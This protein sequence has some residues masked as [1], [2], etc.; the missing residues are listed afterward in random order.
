MKSKLTYTE[1]KNTAFLAEAVCRDLNQNGYSTM[2]EAIPGSRRIKVTK[3]GLLRMAFGLRI[4][5]D[6]DIT[7]TDGGVLVTYTPTFYRNNVGG[8]IITALIGA[9]FLPLLL[10][11]AYG[12][13]ERSGLDEKIFDSV[14]RAAM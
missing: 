11:Q 3:D 10:V 2:T 12:L 13:I 7:T 6:V 14:E 5:V 4:C 8:I 9:T 1:K